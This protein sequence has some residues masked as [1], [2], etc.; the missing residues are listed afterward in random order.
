V[1]EGSTYLRAA[2]FRSCDLD[3]N[4]TTLKIEV[5][6]DILKMYLHTENE[7]ARLSHS[8]LSG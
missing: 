5:H 4:H 3:I 8:E 1:S 6:L 7:V 2:A